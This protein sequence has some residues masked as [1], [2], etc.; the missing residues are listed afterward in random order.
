MLIYTQTLDHTLSMYDVYVYIFDFIKKL[1]T[2]GDC[3]GKM[4]K[5]KE[6]FQYITATKPRNKI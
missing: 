2:D 6:K 1:K 4:K 3:I 5:K